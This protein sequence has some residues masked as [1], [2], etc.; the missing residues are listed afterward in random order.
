MESPRSQGRRVV[1]KALA[2]AAPSAAAKPRGR[3]QAMVATELKI[4][5]SEAEMPVPGFNGCLPDE[6]PARRG[7]SSPPEEGPRAAIPDTNGNSA[8]RFA[9]SANPQRRLAH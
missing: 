5:A 2:P 3:Q 7:E 9:P 8:R 4:A 6:L 1:Q